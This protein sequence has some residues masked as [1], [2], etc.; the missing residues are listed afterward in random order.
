[1]GKIENRGYDFSVL[2]HFEKPQ[3][4]TEHSLMPTLTFVYLYKLIYLPCN[5]INYSFS[6][7]LRQISVT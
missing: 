4:I 3:A 6:L 2:F 7:G 5:V 1:M